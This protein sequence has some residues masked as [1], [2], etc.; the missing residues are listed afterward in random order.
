MD[1]ANFKITHNP[2][3]CSTCAA[4]RDAQLKAQP[5]YCDIC[6]GPCKAGYPVRFGDFDAMK[7]A[8]ELGAQVEAGLSLFIDLGV[9]DDELDAIFGPAA[10]FEDDNSELARVI[11]EVRV[12]NILLADEGEVLVD[13]LAEEELAHAETLADL[14]EAQERVAELESVMQ[15]RDTAL[16]FSSSEIARLLAELR[17]KD[18]LLV[19]AADAL[20][21]ASNDILLKNGLLTL[22]GEALALAAR[23]LERSAAQERANAFAL[24]SFKSRD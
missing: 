15:A 1:L 12:G 3:T 13:A 20:T 10:E 17:R 19:E 22:A 23:E 8:A 5:D 7:V 2:E 11:G 24:F 18:A 14:Y 9:T 21:D 6:A 4:I 16:S